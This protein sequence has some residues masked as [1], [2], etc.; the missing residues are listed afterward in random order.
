MSTVIKNIHVVPMESEEIRSHV[1]LEIE[2]T[3][4]KRIGSFSPVATDNI[5]DGQGGYLLPGLTDMHLHL[6]NRQME[7]YPALTNMLVACG[8]VQVRE[9]SGSHAVL[10]L[11]DR[12]RSGDAV[13]PDICVL[14]PIVES[15]PLTSKE[16]ICLDYPEQVEE[17]VRLLKDAGYDGIKVYNQTKP[18]VF[19]ALLSA[20]KKHNLPVCGHVPIPV[21]ARHCIE[22]NMYSIEHVRAFPRECLVLAGQKKKYWTPTLVVEK[23]DFQ[24]GEMVKRLEKKA[25]SL[26]INKELYA[27]WQPDIDYYKTVYF[28]MD[29]TNEEYRTGI[30]TF[31]NNGGQIL[32]GTDTGVP[33]ITP[34]YALYEE[35]E[36]LVTAGLSPYQAL[37]AATVSAAQCL[38]VSEQYGTIAEGKRADLMLLRDNPLTDIHS[39]YTLQAVMLRG[40]WYDRRQRE[41]LL[42]Q[43]AQCHLH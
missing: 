34:G 40:H 10:Q 26:G 11:R 14:S 23:V 24:N 17:M 12:I 39:L 4:I 3:T 21:G 8:I 25:I 16:N 22:S 6:G 33:L 30:E 18:D 1:S 19:D 2:G 35:L 27:A 38:G 13:G 29:R 31:V 5:I 37:R 7:D 43:A 15:T 36:E 32:A 9:M 28:R 20:A 41:E 42:L